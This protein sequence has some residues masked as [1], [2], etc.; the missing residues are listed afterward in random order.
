MFIIS[1][2][3]VGSS[4]LNRQ[5]VDLYRKAVFR[6]AAKLINIGFHFIKIIIKHFAYHL[7]IC[8]GHYHFRH[9][10]HQVNTGDHCHCHILCRNEFTAAHNYYL[11][12]ETASSAPN[13]QMNTAHTILFFS[14]TNTVIKPFFLYRILRLGCMQHFIIY[15]KFTN[16]KEELQRQQPINSSN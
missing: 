3:Y 1:A 15:H 12:N 10:L 6:D 2:W 4:L 14:L 9:F 11:G 13:T 16:K 7:T 8:I 5:E